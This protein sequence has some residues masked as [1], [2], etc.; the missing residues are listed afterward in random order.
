MPPK[1]A[2]P[3]HTAPHILTALLAALAAAALGGCDLAD[4]LVPDHGAAETIKIGVIQPGETFT[5]FALGSELA[6]MELNEQGGVLGRQIEFIYRDNQGEALSGTP[7]RT[8]QAAREL[9]EDENVFA[10]LGVMLSRNAVHLGEI[11]SETETILVTN[12]VT[13]TV[14][15]GN[16]YIFL[17]APTTESQGEALAPFVASPDQ[18]DVQNAA[19]FIEEGDLYSNTIADTFTPPFQAL[20][21]TV[22]ARETFPEGSVDFTPQLERILA[23][24]PDLIFAPSF[25]PEIPLL[26]EQ[27]RAMGYGG[28]FLG[29][30]GWNNPVEFFSA[31]DDNAPLN[32]S[33]YLSNYSPDV[34]SPGV[35]RFVSGYEA[36]YGEPP[37][38]K[39]PKGYDAM[40][41]LGQAIETAGTLDSRAVRDALASAADYD[42]ATFISHFNEHRHPV[43]EIVLMTIQDGEPKYLQQLSP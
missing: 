14:S 27:A 7:E 40:L 30:T 39:S 38:G 35:Q 10:L 18:L 28:L 11:T 32:G 23:L 29:G 24:Q 9:I 8:V 41:L 42:G 5:S 6:R 3:R 25:P 13:S 34:Q 37:A 15:I 17:V 26:I 36:L 19:I 12:A 31:L 43:K 33:Y 22:S 16:D 2:K 4:T 20:G 1:P 21:G